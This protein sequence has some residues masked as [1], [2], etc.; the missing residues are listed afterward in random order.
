M[1]FLVK[2]QAVTTERKLTIALNKYSSIKMKQILQMREKVGYNQGL[3]DG[4]LEA[5]A[6]DSTTNGSEAFKTG[7]ASGYG[8]EYDEGKKKFEAEKT[9]ANNNGYALGKKQDI[10]ANP[11]TYSKHPGHKES[12]ERGFNKS[13]AERIEAKKK[14]YRDL[15]YKDGKKDR[16]SPSKDIT[17]FLRWLIKKATIMHK[18]I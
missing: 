8:K 9:E 17:K 2:H 10:I 12:F 6:G 5:T 16:H 18:K 13:V 4:Y 15:G 14:E 11:D 1:V 3:K 7:Y